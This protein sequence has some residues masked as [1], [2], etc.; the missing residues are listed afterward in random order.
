[1][2]LP[3]HSSIR[4]FRAFLNKHDYNTDKL[5]QRLGRARPPAPDE[6]Q[7][8]VDDSREITTANLLVRLF[9][10]GAPVDAPTVAEFLPEATIR[11]CEE[12][13]FL[14]TVREKVQARVVI[15]P[16]EN[17][18]FVSDAFR[19]LGT[20][21]ASEFILP[22]STHSANFLR[23][24]T[25]RTPV[26][27][28]LDLGCGCGIHALFAAR[29][30]SQVIA[31]GISAAA[32]HYTKFNAMLNDI[33]NVECIAGDLFAPVSD[34]RFDLIVSNPPFVVSPSD[35]FVYRDNA[36]E[37][38]E[39]CKILIQQA[40]RHLREGGHLQM[41][42][43]WVEIRGQ[44]WLER[45]QGWV[46]GCD[47]WVLHAAPVPPAS[48]VEQ[49]V[50]DI[51]GDSVDPG[52]ASE[53]LAYLDKHNVQSIHPGMIVLR[54]RDTEN[55]LHVQKLPGDVTS[56][57]GAAVAS[58]IAAVDFLEACDDDSLLDATLAVSSQLATKRLGSDGDTTAIRL[59]MNNGLSTE[60]EI[61]GTIAAFL[62]YFDGIRLVR[63]CVAEFSAAAGVDLL[64][65]VRAFVSRGFLVP[66]DIA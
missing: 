32:I 33:D 35:R 42:C 30:C 27:T 6:H 14:E 58:G 44:S 21:D 40:P 25:M 7:Q 45:L 53:W 4:D 23:R 10:L 63:Q 19:M 55:W 57:A 49:R 56:D 39:F 51:S 17:L 61:D 12:A 15:V 62:D 2:Q 54:R 47:A 50:S 36:L 46:R 60:A 59:R 13:G 9:L 28:M 34:R 5:T 41:L 26:E 24:L 37:L 29:H 48:Y 20:S 18:L 43:E 3:D 31:T 38:D 52:S 64:A 1:M 16:V 66:V 8:M 65:V 11:F 22:A